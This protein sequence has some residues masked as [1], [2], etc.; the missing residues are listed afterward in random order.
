MRNSIE[1]FSLFKNNTDAGINAFIARKL[2]KKD[3]FDAATNLFK[4]KGINKHQYVMFR[5]DVDPPNPQVLTNFFGEFSD[6][7]GKHPITFSHSDSVRIK[8]LYK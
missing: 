6:K 1:I 5:F 2:D 3:A 8:K 7:L 4:L